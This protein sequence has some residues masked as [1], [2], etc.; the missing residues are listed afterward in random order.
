[1]ADIA[2]RSKRW[3]VEQL[4]AALK[5]EKKNANR[6]GALAALESALAAKQEKN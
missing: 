6:K 4:E 5:F 2:E 3:K 1:M